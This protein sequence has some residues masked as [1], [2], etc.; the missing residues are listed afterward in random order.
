MIKLAWGE[1]MK[2]QRSG[3]AA[4]PRRAIIIVTIIMLLF[5]AGLFVTMYF[6]RSVDPSPIMLTQSAEVG[7]L[8]VP[9]FAAIIADTTRTAEANLTAQA[10]L[11]GE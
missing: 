7:T 8:L 6:F 10:T 11:E 2:G 9:D 3:W 5:L 4:P 1:I